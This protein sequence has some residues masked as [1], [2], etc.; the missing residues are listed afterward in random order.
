MPSGRRRPKLLVLRLVFVDDI[1]QL[2]AELGHSD[3]F[4]CGRG[5]HGVEEDLEMVVEV[6]F[7][8]AHR[9]F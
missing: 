9:F 8:S 7:V 3:R 1:A 4:G 2:G 6:I 5:I